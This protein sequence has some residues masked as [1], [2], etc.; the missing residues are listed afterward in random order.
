MEIRI[1]GQGGLR[2]LQ[3]EEMRDLYATTNIIRG[4]ISEKVEMGGK[5]GTHWRQEEVHTE[6]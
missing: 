5:S 1:G 6:L 2:Q 4:I 3:S